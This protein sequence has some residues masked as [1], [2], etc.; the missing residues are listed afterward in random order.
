MIRALAKNQSHSPRCSKRKR[1]NIR[2]AW[3][4][5]A[6]TGEAGVFTPSKQQANENYYYLLLCEFARLHGPMRAIDNNSP[7]SA[8]KHHNVRA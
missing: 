1:H 2:A 3:L 5:H 6:L 7:Q 4:A 8:I